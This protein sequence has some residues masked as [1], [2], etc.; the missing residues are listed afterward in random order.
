ME[1]DG[2]RRAART[3]RSRLAKRARLKASRSGEIFSRQQRRRRHGRYPTA[4]R[5]HVAFAIRVD[6]IGQE[7]DVAA[8]RW[9]DPQGRSRKACVSERSDGK[10]LATV[11]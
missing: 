9:I 4:K 8:A 7:H 6:A 11:R 3:G 5:V 2:V 10:Q 1:R